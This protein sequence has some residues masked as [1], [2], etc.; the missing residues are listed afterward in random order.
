MRPRDRQRRRQTRRNALRPAAE[1]LEP[2]IALS[3]DIGINLDFNESGDGNPMWTDL[4]N[5]SGAWG[6]TSGS[7]LSLSADG[8]PLAN[9]STWFNATNYP[10]GNYEFSYTGAGTVSFSGA[11]Q[12]V[13]PVTVSDGV[14]TGTV[15]F[16]DPPGTGAIIS[17]AL[18]NVNPSDPMDNFHLMMPGYGN[19][20]T[21]APMFTP[22]F[23]RSLQPFSNIRFMDWGMTNGSTL[24]NWSDRVGP[25]AYRTDGLGGVPYEDMIEL[26]NE[27][28]KDMWINI[29]AAATP[30]FVQSMAQLVAS[31]LDSNL[32]VYVELGNEDWSG[33]NRAYGQLAAAALANP[34]LNHSLG[35]YQLVA[36]QAAYSVVEDGQAF[37]Q[38]FGAGSARVR[39]IL[40]GQASWTAF[41]TYGLQ[42][43][44]QYFGAPSNYIYAV[45]VAPYFGLSAGQNV[46]GLTLN[47]IFADLNQNLTGGLVPE[48]QAD[49]ALAQEY[50]VPMVS[51]EGGQSLV[52]GHNELNFGVMQQA[53]NDPRMY[54]LYV[55]LINDWQQVGG[56]LFDAYQLTGLDGQYGYWGVLPNVTATG[57]QRY[58]A[59]LSTMFQPGDANTDGSVDYADFQALQANYDSTGD[60]WVQGDFNNDGSVNWADLNILRQNLTPS[61]FTPAQFAQQALFGQL[62]SVTSGIALEYDGY[63]VSDAS[64][65]PLASS[66]GTVKLN[67]NSAG[68]PIDLGGAAYSEGLGFAGNSSASF[69]I[70]GQYS[71]FDSTIGV[72][73]SGSTSSSVIFQVY[74]D[75]NLLYQS[76]VMAYGSAAV[77]IEV[78]VARVQKLTLIVEAAPGSTATADHAVWGDARLISTANFGST[79]DTLTWQLSQN[80]EVLS[81]Q[82]ANSFVLP[83]LSGTYT[84]TL[85]VKDA[86]GNTGTASTNVTVVPDNPSA[87]LQLKDSFDGGTWIGRYGGQGSDIADETGLLPEY[88]DVSVSGASTFTWASSTTDTRG[89]E[90]PSGSDRSAT[91]WY[92]PSRFTIDVNLI[93]GQVHDLALYAVDWENAGRSEQIQLINAGTGGVLDT[94]TIPSFHGGVYLQWAVSGNVLIEVTDLSGVNA[95]VSGLF[96][97]SP[98]ATPSDLV[99]LNGASQGNWIGSLG[100]QGYDI[101]GTPANLPSYASVSLSG[102]ST[103]TWAS[104]TTD[105][106]GLEN[107]GGS[108]RTATCW[109]SATSFTIDVDLT[110][111][112]VHDLALYAVDWG[113]PG[114]IEQIQLINAGTG[115]VLDTETISSFHG[116]VYLQW[117]VS[118]NVLIK[119]ANVS[120]PDAVIS[121]L[122]LDSAVP[123]TAS[124]SLV[125]KDATT[126][127]NWIGV[128]GGQGYDIE[129]TPASLPSYA[130]VGTS[131]ASTYTWSSS[132]TDTRGL[133]NPGGSGRTATCWYS[134]TS[135]TIDVD[136]TDGQACDL[137]LYAVDWENAGR[138]EQIQLFNAGTGGVLDTETISSFHGGVYLQWAVSGN[139]LIK[140]TKV[141]GP[142]AVISGL[143][144]DS[145]VPPTTSASLVK[146]DATTQ[147]N[148]IGV[149]GGQGYDIEGTPAS[150][151]SYAFVGTSGASTYTWSSSTT[152][153]RGLE[154]PGGSGRTATCWY[155]ATSFTIDVDLTDG[156]VHDLALYAVDWENA[157]RSE[158]IQLINAGTGGVLDTETISSFH[159]GVYL[160]W[161]VSGNV[162]IKA[163]R[164][165]GTNAVISGLFLDPTSS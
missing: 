104:S 17:M 162:L 42:F 125:K 85:T 35:Q 70:N 160:Q 98:P 120:G 66:T 121:G 138:S 23:I 26:C 106:R 37:D 92:S 53:E 74:G 139:V 140:V 57:S 18:T 91:C 149:Y 9:A 21:P 164:L 78:N 68:Q 22:D 13:G 122:F 112:Q 14:T 93:D 25:N 5:L 6:S 50:G 131:G 63:G 40:G 71:T 86:Q 81:T 61:G 158:Q 8:Y 59:L 154:N 89:L 161:A 73:S 96:F 69:A 94:E 142:N 43:I 41:A 80:G 45:A 32:N 115:G 49:G 95:V 56:Q 36:Q 152:D 1:A 79:P 114:W 151:P 44:Q 145:A 159:G 146:K 123:P 157:G 27:A 113:N 141:S 90:N 34:V 101:E 76:P 30:Q 165:S 11:G 19:G 135:F 67:Q 143:F 109:Y 10:A 55:A 118:G 51:Y 60:Y 147:G 82:T 65:L 28:Q 102:A 46:A 126:Q 116:G 39:P 52:P 4:H 77:P 110:D 148:W 156:Q 163:T 130:F 99:Q 38:A 128:Y 54:Q 105:T 15:A 107:P 2:R 87:A 31:K 88:A 136:L 58:D 16:S 133:E 124:A 83:A 97:A 137:A 153:T 155:S 3:A 7:T 33:S 108:G 29:P 20:T 100:G 119:V 62:A 72:D 144:L 24:A 134:A 84:I 47:Q 129:D 64:D 132:T 75:N 117:A 127:G 150:L 48:L 12:L 111:G 103:F